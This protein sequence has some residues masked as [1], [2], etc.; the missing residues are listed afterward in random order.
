MSS[1]LIIRRTFSQD[2]FLKWF[3]QYFLS[4]AEPTNI[5]WGPWELMRILRMFYSSFDGIGVITATRLECVQLGNSSSSLPTP[6]L[7]WAPYLDNRSCWLPRFT[8]QSALCRIVSCYL[9]MAREGLIRGE[10]I[11]NGL[12]NRLGILFWLGVKKIYMVYI[13][14]FKWL[15][16]QKNPCKKK[17]K[18]NPFIRLSFD[19]LYPRSEDTFWA[20]KTSYNI[21]FLLSILFKTSRTILI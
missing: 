16:S 7:V 10:W 4:S 14:I 15:V 1:Y 17:F 13:W 12:E 11:K 9:G 2:I 8:V 21:F 18:F 3:F 5:M 20:L 6:P 19:F